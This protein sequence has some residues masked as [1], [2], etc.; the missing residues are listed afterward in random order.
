VCLF[1]SYM[2]FVARLG[3]VATSHWLLWW[4]GQSSDSKYYMG[5]LVPIFAMSASAEV[6]IN[7][8]RG[9]SGAIQKFQS[10][11]TRPFI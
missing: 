8:K 6:Q 10:R 2:P 4:C 11:I 1:V 3:P 5:W 9:E 7:G